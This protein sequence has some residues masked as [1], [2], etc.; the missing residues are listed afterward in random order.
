MDLRHIDPTL[1]A[2]TIIDGSRVWK[3]EES[4]KNITDGYVIL[5]PKYEQAHPHVFLS[6]KYVGFLSIYPLLP[7]ECRFFMHKRLSAN[8]FHNIAYLAIDQNFPVKGFKKPLSSIFQDLQYV[9][10]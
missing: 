6:L 2:H 7:F 8:S 10:R 4:K 5:Y 3:D 1:H 9:V